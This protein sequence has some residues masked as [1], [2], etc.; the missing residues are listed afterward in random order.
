MGRTK[1]AI[2]R[3]DTLTDAAASGARLAG[4]GLD[5]MKSLA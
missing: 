2:A 5:E 4:D 3:F 1:T